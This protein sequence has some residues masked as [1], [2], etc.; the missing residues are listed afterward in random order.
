MQEH[1]A[2]GTKAAVLQAIR[3]FKSS[4]K[5]LRTI[6]VYLSFWRFPGRIFEKC[7]CVYVCVRVSAFTQKIRTYEVVFANDT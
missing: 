6:F 1:T 4:Y 2:L 3:R 7:V 5:I